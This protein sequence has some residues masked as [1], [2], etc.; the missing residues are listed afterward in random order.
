[1][2][3]YT[4]LLEDEGDVNEDELPAES[5]LGLIK[6]HKGWQKEMAKWVEEGRVQ[7]DDVITRSVV[8]WLEGN[9]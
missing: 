1:M 4:D 6:S 9:K 2:P 7:S 3:Q 8:W 5:Q